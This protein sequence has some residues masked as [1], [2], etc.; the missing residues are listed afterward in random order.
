MICPRLRF[1]QKVFI[2]NHAQ[3]SNF[4]RARQSNIFLNLSNTVFFAVFEGIKFSDLSIFSNHSCSLLVR[5]SGTYTF[6]LISSSPLPNPFTDGKPLLR[7]RNTLPGCVPGSIFTL[8]TP[9]MVGTSTVPP[10][11]AIG[12]LRKRL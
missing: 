3:Y 7:N 1:I 6:T 8:A 10:R 2:G 4:S 11:A 5:F 12:K 9:S